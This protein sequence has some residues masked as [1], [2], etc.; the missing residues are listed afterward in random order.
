VDT[1]LLQRLLPDGVSPD[2]YADFVRLAVLADKLRHH[3]S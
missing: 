2:M 3:A 1:E